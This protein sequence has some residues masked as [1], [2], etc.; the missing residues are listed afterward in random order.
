MKNVINQFMKDFNRESIF[1]NDKKCFQMSDFL[2][3]IFDL[4]G[5]INNM[6]YQNFCLL[7]TC[8]SS[9]FLPFKIISNVY[10]HLL[11]DEVILMFDSSISS[12][13]VKYYITDNNIHVILSTEFVIKNINTLQIIKK[14]KINMLI[15]DKK[16]RI[17]WKH[18]F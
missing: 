6:K 14:I 4:D 11:S 7:I 12:I 5:K 13:C 1:I 3:F 17:S 8:Q 9:F 18:N 15:D 2:L 16:C 10:K